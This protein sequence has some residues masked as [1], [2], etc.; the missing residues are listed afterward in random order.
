MALQVATHK[1]QVKA[2]EMED[3]VVTAT[4]AKLKKETIG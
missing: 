1:P 3:I 2:F 4:S